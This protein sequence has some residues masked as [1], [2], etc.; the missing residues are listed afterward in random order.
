MKQ[1]LMHSPQRIMIIVMMYSPHCD[2]K[3]TQS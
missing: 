3:G 1:A 2:D